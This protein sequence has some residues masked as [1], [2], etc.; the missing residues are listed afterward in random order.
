MAN[1]EIIGYHKGALATLS[2]ERQELAKMVGVVDQFIKMHI[3]ELKKLGIDLEEEAKKA[4]EQQP[5]QE[6][7]EEDRVA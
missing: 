5:P 1:E 3:E 2:K 4:Q 6:F 7:K